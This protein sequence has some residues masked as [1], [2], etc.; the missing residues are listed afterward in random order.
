[1][2]NL[3]RMVEVAVPQINTPEDLKVFAKEHGLR[4]DWHEPDE[5]GINA[6]V[7][8]D[9]LDNAFGAGYV[10]EVEGYDGE[11]NVVFTKN[12][13]RIAVVNLANVLAWA[14]RAVV[15]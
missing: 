13:E 5:Q 1:M 11:L 4:P 12:G 14:T 8:G 6:Y 7:Y 3:T 10:S 15:D 2:P 9:D